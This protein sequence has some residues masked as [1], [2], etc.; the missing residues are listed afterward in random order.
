MGAGEC[1]A[2][3]CQSGLS[4]DWFSDPQA[5]GYMTLD[6]P[7][8]GGVEPTQ[9]ASSMGSMDGGF[10]IVLD[11]AAKQLAVS[12]RVTKG[13]SEIPTSSDYVYFGA[14][15][16]VAGS[17]VTA[18]NIV[19]PLISMRDSEAGTPIPMFSTSAFTDTW[20]EDTTAW[21]QHVNGWRGSP[22]EKLSWAVNFRVDLPTLGVDTA[23]TFRVA[24]AAHVEG[25]ADMSTPAT[26][27]MSTDKPTQWSAAMAIGTECVTPLVL[28]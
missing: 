1:S 10:I 2:L 26:L 18:R 16:N 28:Q 24:V 19:I 8:W 21:V 20:H 11:R 23:K 9:F 7:R 3:I 17:M 14:T 25:A 27:G 22:N 5:G 15:V 6:D 13:S 4:P 12:V